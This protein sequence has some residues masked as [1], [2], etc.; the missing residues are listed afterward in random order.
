MRVAPSGDGTGAMGANGDPNIDDVQ[1][2]PKGDEYGKKN[3]EDF[4]VGEDCGVVKGEL[5]GEHAGVTNAVGR[6]V[7]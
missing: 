2:L 6:G 7:C 4:V 3:V 5:N 1:G